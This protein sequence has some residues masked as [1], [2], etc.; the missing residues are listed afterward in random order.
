MNLKSLLSIS[1]LLLF[2]GCA[3]K[4]DKIKELDID[5]TPKMQTPKVVEP[6]KRKKG[7]LYSRRG[8]SLFADKKD[9]QVGDII[10]IQISETLQNTSK[11]ERKTDKTNSTGINGGL[12]IGTSAQ[13][14]GDINKVVDAANGLLGLSVKG[15]STNSF[16]G[17][18]SSIND[19]EFITSISAIIEQTYQNGNYFIK[20]SKEML[21]NGQKQTIKISGV[22]R[23]YDI[24]PD[25]TIKSSQMANLKVLYDKKGSEVDATQKPWGSELLEKISPY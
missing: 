18:S 24:T 9:L 25:N 20:G 21:I 2:T 22:I 1:L 7:T 3:T 11:D 13:T 6:I 12:S 8:A 10:Q 4:Q 14:P 19:E 23:P 15:G 17:K 5:S 16:S